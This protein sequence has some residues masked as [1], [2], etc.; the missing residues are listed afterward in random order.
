MGMRWMGYRH[1]FDLLLLMVF[2]SLDLIF[3]IAEPLG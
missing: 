2:T 3:C 1:C